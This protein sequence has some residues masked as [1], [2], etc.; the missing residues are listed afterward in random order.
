MVRGC[1]CLPP[2]APAQVPGAGVWRSWE[3]TPGR[4]SSPHPTNPSLQV[5]TDT[6]NGRHRNGAPQASSKPSLSPYLLTCVFIHVN[7]AKPSFCGFAQQSHLKNRRPRLLSSSRWKNRRSVRSAP[8]PACKHRFDGEGA[9]DGTP[10]PPP[11]SEG[12]QQHPCTYLSALP[13]PAQGG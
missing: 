4:S 7:I 8:P 10:R 1:R 9:R 12:P 3:E 6:I 13:P 5:P 2:R 11:L